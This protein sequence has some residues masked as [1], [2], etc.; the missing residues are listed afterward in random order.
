[1][2]E[3]SFF[4]IFSKFSGFDFSSSSAKTDLTFSPIL[5]SS[6]ALGDY[7]IAAIINNDTKVNPI[8]MKICANVFPFEN[9]KG[10]H[11]S[12]GNEAI[13]LHPI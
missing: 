1:L 3:P 6:Y 12:S 13:A 5:P 11:L 2:T 4:S 10:L 8:P 9:V 7:E